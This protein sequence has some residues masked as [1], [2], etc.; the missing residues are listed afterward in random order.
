M[1]PAPARAHRSRG[2]ANGPNAA[3]AAP[4]RPR[5]RDPRASEAR[6]RGPRRP[7]RSEDGG[8]TP[9]TFTGG[10]SPISQDFTP[11]GQSSLAGVAA[12]IPF[13]FTGHEHDP[14]V[15]LI[16]MRGRM[17]D[18]VVGRFLTADP[19]TSEP[20]STQGMNRYS[21]VGNDPL[22]FV[23]P[24]GFQSDD[25]SRG[26]GIGPGLVLGGAFVGGGLSAGI[27]S[28]GGGAALGGLGGQVG[29]GVAANGAVELANE[30]I[31][32]LY[33][34]NHAAHS[35]S[36]T[37]VTPS[38]GGGRSGTPNGVPTSEGTQ[39]GWQALEK[40]SPIT[41]GAAPGSSAV[42]ALEPDYQLCKLEFVKCNWEAG[43]VRIRWPV[44]APGGAA[45][46]ASGTGWW[47]KAGAWFFR[48]GRVAPRTAVPTAAELL[49]PGGAKIGQAG[50]SASVR[51]LEGG[52]PAARTLFA[53]LAAGGTPYAGGYAGEA[54][55]SLPGGGFVGLRMTAT[56][57]G[58]R[59]VPAATIDVRIPGIAIRELKFLP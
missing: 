8:A 34:V 36:K 47:A 18:P 45:P 32:G 12:G 42:N 52:E 27:I 57:T 40:G 29:G 13:G 49:I 16:N 4:R 25:I 5:C 35:Y 48:S 50:A 20:L 6:A 30:F 23:D 9:T 44:D 24:S 39:S 46:P 38:T 59:A 10:A 37:T 56:G 17:Y 54:A 11:F 33:D 2:N 53:K 3:T 7:Q 26:G 19:F 14:E 55:V 51:V 22:N 58:A 41:K 21:Y 43:T 28:H 1:L 15:G 31:P